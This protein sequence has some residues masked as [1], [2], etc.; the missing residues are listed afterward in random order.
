MISW[1]DSAPAQTYWT[2]WRITVWFLAMNHWAS[3]IME[4]MVNSTIICQTMS[5]L[6]AWF[7]E[8]N[9]TVNSYCRM[10]EMIP[11]CLISQTK[12]CTEVCLLLPMA[13]VIKL[14]A[15]SCLLTQTTTSVRFTLLITASNCQLSGLI[16]KACSSSQ[17]YLSRANSAIS[18]FSNHFKTIRSTNLKTRP[19][20][21]K[22]YY[23]RLE[24]TK[25]SW[26]A[27]T[28]LRRWAR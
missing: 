14:A 27:W 21:I 9:K 8:Q 16:L 19:I 7:S 20:N 1:W 18:N 25:N 3:V 6:R 10:P 11:P 26:D 2:R 17:S 4:T 13:Q 15:E 12:W 5:V 23:K 22:S 24:S 28:K